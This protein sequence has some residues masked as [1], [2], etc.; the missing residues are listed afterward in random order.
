MTES[1]QQ[2]SGGLSPR[3]NL[4]KSIDQATYDINAFELPKA[5]EAAERIT[6]T[7]LRLENENATLAEQAT[8]DPLT[9]L[10]NRRA[11]NSAYEAMRED[12]IPDDRRQHDK[13]NDYAII[14]DVDNFKTINDKLGHDQG[15]VLL[16]KLAEILRRNVRK[17]DSVGR[18]GG[19]ENVV[20]LP[21]ATRDRVHEIAQKL[22]KEAR[23][24]GITISVG[25]GKLDF[26]KTLA[27]TIVDADAAL[28]A[29]KRAGK[30]V[31]VDFDQ[32]G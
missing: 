27:E 25:V 22:V 6:E 24:L 17:H 32:L 16:V 26:N 30:D 21:R 12:F 8:V 28:F 1:S 10:L 15:D 13:R 2:P 20:L 19:D 4:A 23:G 29:A 14:T 9:A 18:W 7:M 31:V 3:F 11:L 5:V